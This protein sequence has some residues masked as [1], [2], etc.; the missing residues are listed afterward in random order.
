MLRGLV[1]ARSMRVEF[2]EQP[3]EAP[4][5][6]PALIV[7]FWGTH[8][9]E[10][11]AVP[12]DEASRE[13]YRELRTVARAILPVTGLQSSDVPAG[14]DRQIAYLDESALVKHLSAF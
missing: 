7:V 8:P 1:T 12:A 10:V 11:P 5:L 3:G 2:V 13:V 4:H 14:S 6:S 9:R